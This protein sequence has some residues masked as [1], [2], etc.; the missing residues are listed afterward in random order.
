MTNLLDSVLMPQVAWLMACM[1]YRFGRL[2]DH[3]FG[4]WHG[5]FTVA[6]KTSAYIMYDM[7]DESDE[8]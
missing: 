7:N 3:E 6:G 5:Y 8:S 2:L 4:I 1:Y